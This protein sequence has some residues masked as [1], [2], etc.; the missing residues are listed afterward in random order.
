MVNTE[1]TTNILRS[2]NENII[3]VAPI[4]NFI[5]SLDDMFESFLRNDMANTPVIREETYWNYKNL[6]KF[7]NELAK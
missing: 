5:E 1:Q 2:L 3:Q 6:R 4:E 7:L